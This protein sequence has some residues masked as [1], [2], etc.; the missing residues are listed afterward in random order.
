MAKNEL[1][2]EPMNIEKPRDVKPSSM[3][4]KGG[5]GVGSTPG[6]DQLVSQGDMDSC[7]GYLESEGDDGPSVWGK[8]GKA[9]SVGKSTADMG[10]SL[11]M[12]FTS[13]DLNSGDI[14]PN[15]EKDRK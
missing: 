4:N 12:S 7:P 2:S 3:P 13:V 15:V 5:S 9:F 8:G 1:V 10:T 11:Q 6:Q 14:I